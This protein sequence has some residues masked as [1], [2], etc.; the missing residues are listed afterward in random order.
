[1]SSKT[2]HSG[3]ETRTSSCAVNDNNLLYTTNTTNTLVSDYCFVNYDLPLT[4][5]LPLTID[6]PYINITENIKLEKNKNNFL[7]VNDGKEA[8]FWDESSDSWS[9]LKVKVFT[10][11]F[12]EKSYDKE[13]AFSK[14]ESYSFSN[15][16]FN[17]INFITER[18]GNYYIDLNKGLYYKFCNNFWVGLDLLGEFNIET[19]REISVNSLRHNNKDS[20]LL[21]EKSPKLTLGIKG[22]SFLDGGIIYAP[23]IPMNINDEVE[24]AFMTRYSNFTVNNDFYTTINAN[25]TN[26][27][28]AII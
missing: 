11:S 9:I 8:I 1:M 23:Y 27:T 26:I 20:K 17:F 24:E 14:S 21:I 5:D 25:N 19:E 7:I 13:L 6:L 12:K 15:N 2:S 3:V 18:D 28:H 22:I 10:K 16:V 4:V